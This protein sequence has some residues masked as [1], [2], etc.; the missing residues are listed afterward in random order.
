M[1][2]AE[3]VEENRREQ[4]EQKDGGRRGFHSLA[5]GNSAADV[6]TGIWLMAAVAA[7]VGASGNESE[8]VVDKNDFRPDKPATRAA[9]TT[10]SN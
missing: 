5:V 3:K 2:V 6:A 10:C 4:Q 7:V 8:K 9:A 1:R